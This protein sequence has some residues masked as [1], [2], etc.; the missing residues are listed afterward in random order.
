[1]LA[2]MAHTI[3]ANN[4]QDQKFINRFCQGMDPGTM[5]EWAKGQESFKDYILG[6]VDGVPKTPEWAE[7]ICGVPAAD[8][9]KLAD[10]YART[11][12]A[13]LK[14]SWA[15]AWSPCMINSIVTPALAFSKRLNAC[16]MYHWSCGSS[17]SVGPM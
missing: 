14:A 7:Q 15:A 10:M 5:P 17:F 6:T 12:P 9:R 8:I 2:G 3:F 16:E 11:K 1:M 4:L 13:A